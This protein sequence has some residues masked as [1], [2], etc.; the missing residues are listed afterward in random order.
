MISYGVV[1]RSLP[2]TRAGI[3]MLLDDLESAAEV[4]EALNAKGIEVDVRRMVKRDSV[5]GGR[6]PTPVW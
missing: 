6:Q 5:P 2:D 3:L 4:A 1:L